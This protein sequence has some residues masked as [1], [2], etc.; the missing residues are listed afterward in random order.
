MVANRS[1]TDNYKCS[2]FQ[3]N[4]MVDAGVIGFIMRGSVAIGACEGDE[5]M[6]CGE[7]SCMA[8]FSRRLPILFLAMIA[9]T[10]AASTSRGG[11]SILDHLA[12]PSLNVVMT[13]SDMAAAKTF[14]GQ[15][16]GLAPLPPIR[17]GES[18]DP[19]FFPGG[20]TMERFRVG[21]H[22]IKLI[23]GVDSTKKHP[24]GVASGIGLRLVNYPI[25]DIA[26]FRQRL[27]VHGYTEPEIHALPKSN[28]RFGL[29]E[30]PDGNPVEFY[31]Y[32]GDGPKGWQESLHL[33]LTVSDVEA[34]RKFYGQVL[35]LQELPSMPMPLDPT[36]QVYFFQCGPTLIKFWS[37]GPTL[38]KRAGR[39]LDTYGYRYIQY[40]TRDV[41]KAR[42]FVQSRG[43]KIDLPPTPVRSM[44]VDI[45]FVADPDGVINEMF[46][47]KLGG[48]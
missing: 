24:G 8:Q 4:V 21:T 7:L 19:V 30:D 5:Q 17:F 41:T 20:A 47:V 44:P 39:H 37:F 9:M 23:P 26:A 27:K 33:A 1:T 48:Q 45:M 14:Y 13:V 15:V 25:A 22:E 43:G 11:E 40:F 32:E 16:L 3:E 18:T 34:S 2:H 38:P 46:G 29:L 42:E 31:Y 10:S 36:R 35:G 28:Y 12:K 6:A